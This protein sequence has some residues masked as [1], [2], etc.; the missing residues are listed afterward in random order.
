MSSTVAGSTSSSSPIARV[1]RAIRI[2]RVLFLIC[3]AAAAALLGVAAHLY[4]TRSEQELADSH[5]ES[6][7]TRALK[8][9]VHTLQAKRWATL[10]L[11][12]MISQMHPTASAWPL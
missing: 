1:N 6:I 8:D 7:A 4:L 2:S 11:A 9:A 3:L 5:L 12:S 10:T